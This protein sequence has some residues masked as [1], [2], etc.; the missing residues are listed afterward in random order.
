M[1]PFPVRGL[2]A[3]A[4][5]GLLGAA[6]IPA[7]VERAISGGAG[8]I[9]YRDKEGDA[10]RRVETAAILLEVCRR[11]R[12]PLIIND[13]VVLTA[14]IGADGAHLGREDANLQQARRLLGKDAII[15]VSCYNEPDLALAAQ[16]Q[17]A[18]YVAFGRFFP[19]RT[20][21]QA[22]HATLEML[23]G[24]RPRLQVPVVAIGGITPENG[25]LLLDAGADLLAVIHGVF[26]DPDPKA[27]AER[28]ARL[29]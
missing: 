27:A 2:Y 19:S 15:G 17:G 25:S 3:I 23:R 26:G 22:I 13:D 10:S 24:I 7:V 29:F 18:D 16:E 21:P 11:H 1:T 12:V 5:S 20:K 8:V 28:F 4:D 9:Q 6:N 14:E